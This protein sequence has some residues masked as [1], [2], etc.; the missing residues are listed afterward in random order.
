MPEMAS[1]AAAQRLLEGGSPF[2]PVNG[3]RIVQFESSDAQGRLIRVARYGRASDPTDRQDEELA[4]ALWIGLRWPSGT[5]PIDLTDTD[6][7]LDRWWDWAAR[8][9]WHPSH[10]RTGAHAPR[11][12]AREHEEGPQRAPP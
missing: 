1:L 3:R 2:G 7:E 11:H 5:R 12:P 9:R 8:A 10:R 4:T 6:G